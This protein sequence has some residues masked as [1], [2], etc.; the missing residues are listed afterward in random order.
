MGGWGMG[1]IQEFHIDKIELK[2]RAQ[3]KFLLLRTAYVS[4]CAVI[5]F[6][7]KPQ[8][9][10]ADPVS[11]GGWTADIELG[12]RLPPGFYYIDTATYLER[13][14][15]GGPRIDAAVN[16]PVFAW[17]TPATIFGGRLAFLAV[18]PELGVGINPGG[19]A[20]SSW[21]RAFYN[22]AGLTGIAWV[23]GGGWS[24]S[25]YIGAFVPVDTSVGNITALGGNFW[26]FLDIISIAYNH[27]KWTLSANFTFA[28]SGHDLGSGLQAQPDTA[29][30]DFAATKHFDKWEFGLVGYGS[31]DLDGATR[32]NFG[33]FKQNQFALGGLAGYDFGPV[34]AQ[35]YVTRDLEETNYAGY[36]TRIWARLVIPL[37]NPLAPKNDVIAKTQSK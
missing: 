2:N 21:Y 15:S 8:S 7:A 26:T 36:D 33:R 29:Q 10:D 14:K 13:Y 31:T 17:S 16:I 6:V 32:N 23:L 11:P 5:C 34:T 27:D 4:L 12:A 19:G 18:V 20:G 28:H 22:P 1:E 3:Q 25:N 35:I 30:V 9:V 37:G 24:F